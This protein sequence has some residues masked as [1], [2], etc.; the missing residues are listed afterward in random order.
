MALQELRVTNYRSLRDIHLPLGNLN[1]IIGPNGSGKSNLYRAIWLLAQ[2]SE[3]GFARAIARE[4]GLPSTL[5]CRS[6]RPSPRRDDPPIQHP[7]GNRCSNGKMA[8]PTSPNTRRTWGKT[9]RT[10]S[11]TSDPQRERIWH[12]VLIV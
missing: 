5:W 10:A 12:S 3:G 4:G 11:R 7:L 9:R 8:L 6:N 1:V 2:I